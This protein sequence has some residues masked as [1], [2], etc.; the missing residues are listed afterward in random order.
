LGHAV[1]L[2]RELGKRMKDITDKW[3]ADRAESDPQCSGEAATWAKDRLAQGFD[4]RS[5]LRNDQIQVDTGTG[6]IY[7]NPFRGRNWRPKGDTDERFLRGAPGTLIGEEPMVPTHDHTC[8]ISL[9]TKWGLY[10]DDDPLTGI[11]KI[12]FRPVF[13]LCNGAE[14]GFAPDDPIIDV[15]RTELEHAFNDPRLKTHLLRAQGAERRTVS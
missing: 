12:T 15:F 3:Y 11:S 8:K 5:T 9:S 4:L 2:S 7:Y 14:R 1:P 6:G 13:T 10:K